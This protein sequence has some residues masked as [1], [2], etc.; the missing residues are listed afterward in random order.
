MATATKK[1][2]MKTPSKLPVS[3]LAVGKRAKYDARTHS[4]K[5]TIKNIYQGGRGQWVVVSSKEHGDVTV[6]PSQVKLY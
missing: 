1:P 2:D 6:R 4:G 3:T 5:G